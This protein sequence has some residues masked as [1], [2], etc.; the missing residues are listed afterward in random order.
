VIVVVDE[1]GRIQL[2]DAANLQALSVE[3]R[4]SDRAAAAAALTGLG[5]LDGEHAWLDIA[6]LRARSPLTHD[7]AW[8]DG[9]DGAMAYARSKGWIDETG[10]HV[11]A[12][13]A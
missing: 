1:G 11:R 8:C 12:H 13:L 6:A 10:T 7:P 3:L 5:R 4:G 9:F 2:Q